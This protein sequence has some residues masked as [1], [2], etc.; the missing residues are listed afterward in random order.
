[1]GCGI[2]RF[3]L[4]SGFCPQRPRMTAQGPS[5]PFEVPCGADIRGSWGQNPGP[6]LSSLWGL[7]L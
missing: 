2:A 5:R 6:K 4:G 7:Y 3:G 1:M